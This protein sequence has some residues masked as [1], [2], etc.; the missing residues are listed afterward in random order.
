MQ[1]I[2]SGKSHPADEP[3]KALIQRVYQLSQ[4][5]DYWGKIVFVEN[6]DMNI[7][8]H[9]VAGVDIWLNNPR[10]PH[11]ASGTSGMK[12]SLSGAPNLSVLG[13]LVGGGL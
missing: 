6:Y 5:P 10:R 7:A 1:I 2:F 12:A 9:L 8:R 3:G 11:E 13:R 4:Q